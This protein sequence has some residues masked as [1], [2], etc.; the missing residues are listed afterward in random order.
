MKQIIKHLDLIVFTLLV[1]AYI[2]RIQFISTDVTGFF[3]NMIG[4][5]L[6]L[7]IGILVKKIFSDKY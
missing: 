6:F 3:V 4:V 2:I 1:F 7:I 5:I